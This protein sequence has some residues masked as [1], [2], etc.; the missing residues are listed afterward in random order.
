MRHVFAIPPL[1]LLT[2]WQSQTGLI[3]LIA[4][5]LVLIFVWRK[6]TGIAAPGSLLPADPTSRRLERY[7]AMAIF[8]FIFAAVVLFLASM[9]PPG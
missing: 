3:L 4:A 8:F 1:G 6:S 7:G 5:A 9:S 2:T